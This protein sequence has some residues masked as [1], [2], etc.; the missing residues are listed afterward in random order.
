[1]SKF[2]LKISFKLYWINLDQILYISWALRS[3]KEFSLFLLWL[4]YKGKICKLFETYTL[5]RIKLVKI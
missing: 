5:A 2:K 3:R 1:M 4:L